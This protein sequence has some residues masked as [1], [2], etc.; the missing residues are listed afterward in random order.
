MSVREHPLSDSLGVA[1]AVASAP[2]KKRRVLVVSFD[3]PPNR[4]SAVY[5]MVGLTKSL[6]QLGWQPTVLTID[7]GNFALEPELLDR[8]PPQVE[9]ARTKFLR[10]NAWEDKTASAMHSIGALH[11]ADSAASRRR[12][13][14]LLRYL[15][16]QMRSTLYFPD[17]TIGWIPYALSRAIQLHR[18]Q[19]FDLVYTTAPPRAAS[20][21]GLMLKLLYGIPLVTEFMDPWYAP[22]GPIRRRSE[23]WLQGLLFRESDRVV[24]MIRQHAEELRRAH[25]I[26]P[27]KLTVVRNGFF[28]EDF[29]ALE[30]TEPNGLDPR[31]FHFSH[32]GTIYPGNEGNLFIALAEMLEEHPE[33]KNK[34]RLH[35]VGFPCD[36]VLH[37]T[38]Q[39][40]L[41]E[42]SE[43]HGFLPQR[44]DTLQMMRASDCLLLCWGRPE[45][46]RWAVAGKTYDYLRTGRPILAVTAA[47]SGVEELVL[48]SRAGWVVPPNDTQAIKC[49]LRHILADQQKRRAS[50]PTRPEYVAQ[51]RWDR[52]AERLAQAFEEAVGYGR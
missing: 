21:V 3:F 51:F 14:R 25:G 29:T 42:I 39:T 46:S 23:H 49:V 16:Q 9:I 10:I 48:E 36:E 2:S 26:P 4:T 22:A 40:A 38:Q 43:F 8:L 33:L 6:P 11:K 20:V 19:P 44:E 12:F 24:V 27:E 47:G 34:I 32:F 5:R 18:Q 31:Y 37:Y 13:D 15:G 50:G 30:H 17:E 52:L 1:S 35:L 28:E 7:G 45:F 41:R